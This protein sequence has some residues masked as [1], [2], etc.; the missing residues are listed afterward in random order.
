MI[1]AMMSIHSISLLMVPV[2][3][4][5]GIAEQVVADGTVGEE[6]D[7]VE[8]MARPALLFLGAAL[9]AAGIGVIVHRVSPRYASERASKYGTGT[10]YRRGTYAVARS[11]TNGRNHRSAA[12]P[13]C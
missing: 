12:Y 1:A 6:P 8:G 5:A 9:C 13:R 7:L 11:R 10:Y 3:R 2:F 4:P